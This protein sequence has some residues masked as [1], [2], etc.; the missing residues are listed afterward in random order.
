MAQGCAPT[1]PGWPLQFVNRVRAWSF[2]GSMGAKS[3]LGV[4]PAS[5]DPILEGAED[6]GRRDRRAGTPG[7]PY[8]LIMLMMFLT[9]AVRSPSGS[10][11]RNFS[12]ILTALALSAMLR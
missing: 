2:Y 7:R 11:V 8:F 5:G 1:S 4:S 10:S 9:R 12:N 6:E 3:V